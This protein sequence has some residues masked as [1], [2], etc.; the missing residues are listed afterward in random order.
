MKQFYNLLEAMAYQEKCCACGEFLV[1]NLK[2]VHG[3]D[4][5]VF[6]WNLSEDVDSE[7]DDYITIDPY[8]QITEVKQNRRYYQDLIY[9]DNEM[10]M[11]KRT[12]SV[13]QKG[14]FRWSGGTMYE[15][16]QKHCGKCRKYGY[17]IQV[18]INGAAKKI[19]GLFL[20]SEFVEYNDESGK[21]HRIR[22]VYTHNKTEYVFEVMPTAE[23]DYSKQ[24]ISVPLIPIDL[25]HPQ[26]TVSRIKKLTIFS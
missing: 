11:V 4:Y 13:H 10:D 17:T 5:P 3:G 21:W 26:E 7:T 18:I 15:A 14:A 6:I 19:D 25:N 16:I 20:N 2:L 9:S 23:R 24:T 22:N 8:N 1:H 12:Y